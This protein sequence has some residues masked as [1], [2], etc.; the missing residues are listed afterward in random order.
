[1]IRVALAQINE[2]VGDVDGNAERLAEA[3]SV[4]RRRGAQIVAAPELAV[5]GY[6]PEDLVLKPSFVSANLR[7]LE[8]VAR[9]AVDVVAIVGFVEPEGRRLYDAAAVCRGGEIVAVYRKQLLPNYGVFDERRYFEPG[10]EHILFETDAGVFGVSVCEDAWDE[11]GPVVA[12]GRAGAQMVININAS[13]FHKGKLR[14]RAEM[15]GERARQAGASIA[16]VNL[17]GG[18]DELVFDGGSLVIDPQGEVVARFPQFEERVEVVDVPLGSG[19][20]EPVQDVH[21]MPLELRPVT[22]SPPRP[23]LAPQPTEEGELYAALEL[24]LSDYVRKNAFERVLV[25]LSGGID[26]SLTATI[27][28]D[29]LGADRVT[30]IAMPSEFSTSHSVLDAKELAANLGIELLEIPIAAIYDAYIRVLDTTIGSREPGIAEE[31]LQAR[32][33]GNTLMFASNRHGHLVLA[34]GN[35][36]ESACGYAT[37]YGDMAGGFALIK[38]VFKSQVYALARHRNA[39]SPVIPEN[40]LTKAPSA[41]LRADQKDED[42][43]PPYSVL[44]PILEAYI[45]HEASLE[46]IVARGFERATVEDVIS[47]VDRAEYKRRQAPPGPKVTTKAFGRDRR[48][49]ISNAWRESGRSRFTAGVGE[50]GPNQ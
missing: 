43:L 31:N 16:Y 11:A 4:G 13:P 19:T 6:P 3:I 42:S 8:W 38:D 34:T 40:V 33:R 24:A 49:P 22:G 30:G 29:G 28:A 23:L 48:L 46:S 32:I 9:A 21:R 26:S 18:Q 45:E 27:A 25:G 36:S 2:R 37:L 41:E 47:M 10:I 35:K 44:D 5:T 7:A 1:M 50:A 12:Q 20:A 39:L 14:E 17:V 15:L